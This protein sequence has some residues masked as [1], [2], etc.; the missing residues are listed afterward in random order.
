MVFINLF[1]IYAYILY[2]IYFIY[3][4]TLIYYLID[5]GQI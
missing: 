3:N 4:Y 5:N 1:F 2:G